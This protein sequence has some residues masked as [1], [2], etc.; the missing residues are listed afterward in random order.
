MRIVTRLLLIGLFASGL[1][2]YGLVAPLAQQPGTVTVR[3]RVAAAQPGVP[4]VKVT[5]DRSRVPDGSEVIFTLS[6]ARIVS[7]S[8]YR[9][10]LFFGDGKRQVVR[11]A[12]V[13]H[14]YPQSGTYTYAVLVEAEKR[15]T[16]SPTPVSPIP[17]VKL[18]ASPT[19][20]EVN[21]PVSFAAQLSHRYPNLKYRFVFGDGSDTGWQDDA[22]AAHSYRS[23]NTFKAYVDIGVFSNGAVKQAGGSE[24]ESIK[25]TEPS[26]PVNASVKLSANPTS[27][28]A[29]KSVAFAARASSQT[30]NAKYR[31][32]FGD[33][34]ATD[35]QASPRATHRYNTAGKYSARIDLRVAN[36][37]VSDTATIE[38]NETAG[39]ATVDLKVIPATAPLGMP[40]LFQAAP[41]STSAKAVY[42]FNFGDGSAPTGWSAD[43]VQTHLYAGARNYA[44][45][46]EMAIS[47]SEPVASGKKRVRITSIGPIPNTNGNQNS[48]SNRNAN[49]N[50][51]P[52]SNTNGDQ[53]SNSNRNAN[54]NS[55]PRSNANGNQNS[56]SIRNAN[57]AGETNANGTSNAGGTPNS[58]ANSQ[59]NAN[60]N[61]NAN[62]TGVINSNANV[63]PVATQN[64][65]GA[66]T[67]ASTDWWKYA[68]I[69]AII[70]F[71]LYQGYSY[72]YAPRPTFVPH[73]DPGDSKVGA[74]K[75]LSI[76]LQVDVDPN[77][78]AGEVRVDTQG[79]S[80]IK[81]KRIEP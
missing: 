52:R 41:S 21:R 11:Q 81:S 80:L 27:I 50:S 47:G 3:P 20:A 39:K 55:T 57:V 2:F 49:S 72:F 67:A 54:S 13:T 63:S 36:G 43:P 10:T 68:I 78:S 79:N 6:P 42:R 14:V 38:V 37:T 34:S 75:P 8:S 24:R 12:K 22:K 1:C 56:N 19:S 26:R 25:V 28:D 30:P 77:I 46:A 62:S 15:S 58:N 51:A 5:V 29:G 4:E 64:P 60:R 17:N 32:D 7:D 74:G 33:K 40:I 70:L 16:P 45:F 69:A 44:A 31:F 65:Q 23:A 71:A 53:N 35:W 59:A 61:A 66:G 73:F 76:D 9:V 18:S 48:N